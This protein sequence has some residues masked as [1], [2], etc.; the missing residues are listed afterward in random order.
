M[1]DIQMH[2][3][4]SQIV[5]FFIILL[6]DEIKKELIGCNQQQ[7]I[8]AITLL[9]LFS[10][11]LIFIFIFEFIY[12]I[13]VKRY[14]IYMEVQAMI[15]FFFYIVTLIFRMFDY[16]YGISFKDSE[17]RFL[18]EYL[19]AVFCEIILLDSWIIPILIDKIR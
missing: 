6:W 3:I 13:I 7:I 8:L 10:W 4:G 15:I 2:I 18:E 17:V 14:F 9:C 1:Y 5:L 16:K 12:E 11:A 19:P